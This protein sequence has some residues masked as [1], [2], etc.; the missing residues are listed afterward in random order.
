MATF[1]ARAIG[2]CGVTVYAIWNRD[3]CFDINPLKDLGTSLVR[4]GRVAA[5]ASLSNAI[6]P[7]GMAAVTAA[8]AIVGESAVAGFGAATRVQSLLF[9]PMLALSSGIGPVVGQAWGA[10]KQERAQ[11]VVRLTFISCAIYGA[12]L[13]VILMFFAE[14]IVKLVADNDEAAGFGAQYLRFVGLSFFGYGILVTGNAAMNARDRALWSMGLSAGR[15]ALV[16]MPFAWA[17]VAILGYSGILVAAIAAN[18]FGALGAIV[19]CRSIGLL[20]T[21]VAGLG[22]AADAVSSV[23]PTD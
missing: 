18:L 8:V 15:I 10:S 21:D 4:I 5:P 22:G 20:R 6:N 11:D 7:A 1:A 13:A 12:A 2:F 3:I 19:A 23:A 9:L 17:G 16:Y 14:P